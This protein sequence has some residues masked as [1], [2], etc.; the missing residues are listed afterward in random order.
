MSNQRDMVEKFS[1]YAKQQRYTRR[2][3]VRAG[4]AFGLSAAV[5]DT[6][7]AM[8]AFAQDSAASPAAGGPDHPVPARPLVHTASCTSR[9]D[10]LEVE[11]SPRYP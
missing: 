5:V 1:V 8:P 7:L 9:L 6:V 2:Q 10:N 11:R 4:A 3:I